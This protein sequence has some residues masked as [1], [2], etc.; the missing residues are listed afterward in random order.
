MSPLS[1]RRD[2]SNHSGGDIPDYGSRLRRARLG[3]GLGIAMITMMFVVFSATYVLRRIFDDWPDVDASTPVLVSH[4][5]HLRLPIALLIFNSFVLL[6]SSATME[7]AR[8][9]ITKRA[10]L[11]PVASIPGVSLGKERY[12]PWLPASIV[13]GFGFLLGQVLAWREMAARGIYLA[14]AP[15]G[16]FVY[17]ATILHAIHLGAGLIA[18]L[19]AAV[20]SL[21]KGS[22]DSQ[23]IITDI[24]AWYWHFMAALWLYLFVLLVVMS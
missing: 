24:S 9:Q 15:S 18:L 14:T 3:L 23:R 6:L 22:W 2:A 11:A 20:M 12:L 8:R 13:L 10:A 19:V 4:W 7:M 17:L 5:T 16:T 21:I 1:T